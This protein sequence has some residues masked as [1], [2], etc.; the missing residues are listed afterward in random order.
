MSKYQYPELAATFEALTK[1]RA[2]RDQ[3]AAVHRLVEANMRIIDQTIAEIEK[4]LI[5]D[6]KERQ[7]SQ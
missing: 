3:A 4:R 7:R 6:Y 1:L 5:A 2:V